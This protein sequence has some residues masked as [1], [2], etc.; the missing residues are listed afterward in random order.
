MYLLP[1]SI[2]YNV[3]VVME[4]YVMKCSIAYVKEI[5][6]ELQ[7]V[8]IHRELTV[9]VPWY[10]IVVMSIGINYYLYLSPSC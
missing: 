2:V 9:E 3:F 6:K 5:M 7:W 4:G 8:V 10:S 1:S